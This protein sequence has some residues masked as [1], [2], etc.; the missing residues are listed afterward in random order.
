MLYTLY[1]ILYIL[2]W[3]NN[4]LQ[5]DVPASRSK[6]AS[7]VAKRAPPA[8]K[9]APSARTQRISD[10]PVAQA[11]KRVPAR[12]RRPVFP[13]KMSPPETPPM[14]I[15]PKPYVARPI[16]PPAEAAQ[17]LQQPSPQQMAHL[18]LQA[19]ATQNRLLANLEYGRGIALM[20]Q[21]D[22]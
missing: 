12:F 17:F 5:R 15:Q 14:A 1:Y 10:F 18:F 4:F 7:V 6:T 11:P 9:E 13:P 8:P 2:R 20:A 3:F 16:L 19:I 22:I 21:Q